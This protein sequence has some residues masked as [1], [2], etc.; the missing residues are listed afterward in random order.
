MAVNLADL[1]AEC[2]VLHSHE[3]TLL[4]RKLDTAKIFVESRIGQKLDEFEDG[5]PAPLD[6][7]VLKVAA[8]L[9]E[10]RGVASETALTQIPEGFRALVNIYRKRPFA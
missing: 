3:D 10:W 2:R 7:A 4:Q 1:K 9:Y 8:H 5:V 6:E